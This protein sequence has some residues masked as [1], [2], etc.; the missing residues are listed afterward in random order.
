MKSLL[1][2][3][4]WPCS[5]LQHTRSVGLKLTAVVPWFFAYPETAHH[6]IPIKKEERAY[7]IL[8]KLI[9]YHRHLGEVLA[10][11]SASLLD[12]LQPSSLLHVDPS[13]PWPTSSFSSTSDV[14]CS[15]MEKIEEQILGI[16]RRHLLLEDNQED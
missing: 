7:S 11:V 10:A 14:T 1:T 9:Y 13:T 15:L 12:Y 2:F 6:Q 5:V 3:P 4:V 16:L 8:I